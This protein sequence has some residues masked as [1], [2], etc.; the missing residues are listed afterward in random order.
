MK[1]KKNKLDELLHRHL[2]SSTVTPQRMSEAARERILNAVINAREE[3]EPEARRK[4]NPFLAAV[5]TA[6][7]VLAVL[8][9]LQLQSTAIDAH[10]IVEYG[11]GKLLEAGRRIDAGETARTGDAS[12]LLTLADGSRVEMRAHSELVLERATDGVRIRLIEGSL[13]INAAKQHGHLYVQTK[14]AT[15]SVVGTVFLVNEE[16]EGSRVAVIEGEVHV[17]HG[18]AENSLMPGEQVMTKPRMEWQPVSEEIAW[19]R[20]AGEHLALLQQSAPLSSQGKPRPEF[21]VASV[22]L[23][24]PASG[25]IGYQG[26]LLNRE[27]YVDRTELLQFIVRAYLGGGSCVMTAT[28]AMGHSCALIA[29]SLPEWVKKDRFEIQAKM[30]ANSVPA[31]TFRQ[32]RAL[33]TPEVNLMLQVLLEDRFHLKAHREMRELPVYTLTVAKNGPKLKKTPPEGQQRKTSDGILVE[34]HGLTGVTAVPTQDSIQRI[35][36]EFLGS[37][38]KETAE[39]FG[40]Y[41]DRPVV[42]RTD[43]KGEYDF[44]IEYEVEPSLR[45]PGN[46]FSGLTPSAL[47]TALQA[48]GLKLESTK[49]PIEVLVI[50]H[51]EKPA[52]N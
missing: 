34:I 7:V 6:L 39:A 26:H 16:A 5:A 48:V 20:H 15:V 22:K 25:V 40:I 17:K 11:D 23:I 27:R 42:D 1:L 50:D 29:G 37:S 33:D 41:F 43:I 35:Q 13:I 45:T 38:M 8:V 24:D 32:T 44:T 14:D 12:A 46:P 18:V 36:M 3:A 4:W 10:A 2:D 51:V 28:P 31:Y 49:A 19:S 52:E 9:G 21:E 30:P 47:S